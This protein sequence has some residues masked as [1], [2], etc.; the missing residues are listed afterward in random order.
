MSVIDLIKEAYL[1][2]EEQIEDD[3]ELEDGNYF[4]NILKCPKSEKEAMHIQS[5]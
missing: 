2:L 1:D 3:S 5:K 4:F